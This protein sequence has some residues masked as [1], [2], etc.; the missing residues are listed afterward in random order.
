YFGD[1]QNDIKTHWSR[2]FREAFRDAPRAAFTLHAGDLINE[3]SFDAE[4]GE[5]HGAPGW[6]NGTIPVI[7]TPG[8][9]EYFRDEADTPNV[10]GHWRPQFTYPIQDV[11]AGLEE[12]TY[13]IDYQGTRFISLD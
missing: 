8:N 9:H 10:S 1:A 13:Y 6:V 12:T 2:V 3:D 11:P 5:W 7:A 4:W